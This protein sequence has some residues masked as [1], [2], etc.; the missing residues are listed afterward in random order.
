[1]TQS[2]Q[3]AFQQLRPP[4]VELSSV[5][6]KFKA[7][8]ASAKAV[9]L[10]LERVHHTL[11][12]LAI[13]NLLDEKLA[14]YAF[15]PLTHIFNQSQRLS[16]R[17]LELAVRCV[18]FLVSKGWREKLVPEMS[19]QLLI[20]M[21][22]LVSRNPKQQVE[23]ATDELKVAAF[24]CMS[25]LV[26]QGSSAASDFLTGVGHNNIVDQ[27]VYQLLEALTDASSELVQI[28]AAHALFEI[29][30]AIKDK[31][32]IASLLP[33]TVSTLVKV[34]RPS[35]QARRTRKVLVAYLRLLTDILKRALADE[36]VDQNLAEVGASQSSRTLGPDG[37]VVPD[38]SW[39]DA[40]TPQVDLAL[41]QVVKLKTHDGSDVADALLDLCLTVINDCSQ[42]LA[43]SVPLM[44]DTLAVLCDSSNESK[45]SAVLK[46]L[47]TSRPELAEVLSAKFYDW[48]QTLPRVMQGND[49]KPK[50]QLLKRVATSF[51]VLTDTFNMPS[52]ATSRVTSVLIDTV[53]AAIGS[54]T[55][56]SKLISETVQIPATELVQQSKSLQRQFLPVLLGHQSQSSSK[57]ELGHLIASLKTHPLSQQI[58]RGLVDHLHDPDINRKLSAAWLA[59]QF[60]ESNESQAFDVLT[61]IEDDVSASDL[62]VS[63]PFLIA[64]L[65]SNALPFLTEYPDTIHEDGTDWRL[66]ALSLESLVLQASQ[67]GQSYRPELIEI[68]F[69][70]L[71]LLGSHNALLQQHAMTALNIL[72]TACEYD[73]VA[74]MLVDNVDYLVNAVALR[75]NAFDVSRT[76]LQV[77]TMMV[78]LCGARLLPHLDDL[79]GSIFGALDSF[80]GYPDLVE[81]LF[82]VLRMVVTESSKSTC[83]LP[84]EA[85]QI[86][87]SRKDKRTHVSCLDDVLGDLRTRRKRKNR[88]DAEDDLMTTTP[89][90]P[91]T[92]AQDGAVDA[93]QNSHEEVQESGDDEGPLEHTHKKEEPK[94]S[95]SHQLLLNIAQ[96]TV[97]H[98]SSPSPKVRLT[99]LELLQDVCPILALHEN[100]FLPLVNLIWPAVVARLL[101]TNDEAAN[102][103][104]FTVRAAATTVRVMCRGAGDFMASR[105]ED[106]FG[107]LE[108]LFKKIFSS[109]VGPEKSSKPVALLNAPGGSP[110]AL[111]NSPLVPSHQSLMTGAQP[112]IFSSLDGARSSK[113]Q[114][115]EA[116][117]DLLV[118][119]LRDVRLSDDN[120]DTVFQLLGSFR[121]RE[122]VRDALLE[123]NEDAVWLLEHHPS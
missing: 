53:A 92:T 82:D 1:M 17:S 71:S 32:L 9:L 61:L 110:S 18:Q 121:H 59:L 83:V 30:R 29:Q 88:S 108:T 48:T 52:A 11:Q 65:Y 69:P 22:L 78:R 109:V 15:F 25:S 102:D 40:T 12:L 116:L 89:H 50:Q 31:A 34:L 60:L 39:L 27:L 93:E 47:V 42:T 37:V 96:S 46:H 51:K 16:S 70:L 99:L 119:I 5:A 57:Q 117:V 79:I 103:A 106:I 43:R 23:P 104:A 68:L 97:P 4:C 41:V 62:S 120:A 118:T 114:I 54:S 113:G 85:G 100:T 64:D 20:L 66:V 91:W 2:R 19:K 86:A 80:H 95:K 44:L 58:I 72:A 90:R 33:R 36:V 3:Q 101:T 26:H 13:E 28:S 81:Q 115:L 73:S 8:Q 63:R 77:V 105:I 94:I 21:G 14:E 75:L 87:A 56:K 45:A 49:D 10:A 38:K 107:E 7:N 84:V 55:K 6:L 122:T 111:T 76:S 74:F 98:L 24:E 67:L 35:T 112:A 123:Y